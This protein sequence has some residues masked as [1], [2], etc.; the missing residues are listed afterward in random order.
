MA[1]GLHMRK[2]S[3][4][5]T[6]EWRVPRGSP[7]RKA[8]SSMNPS[9]LQAIAPFPRLLPVVVALLIPAV[10]QA[11]NYTWV[12]SEGADWIDAGNWSP[13]SPAAT[14]GSG[15]GNTFTISS[16]TANATTNTFGASLTVSG[17]GIL[18]APNECPT[19]TALSLNG[20]T[21]KMS[22][23]GN[24]A[25]SIT[26]TANSTIESADADYSNSFEYGPFAGITGTSTRTLAKTGPGILNL[27]AVDRSASY[28]GN[29]NVAG[30]VVLVGEDDVATY[31]GSGAMVALTTAGSTLRVMDYNYAQ[32]PW[33]E[34]E[35]TL[36]GIGTLSFNE[37]VG[38]RLTRNSA[39]TAGGL[40]PGNGTGA[41]GTLTANFDGVKNFTFRANVTNDLVPWKIDVLSSTS[42]DNIVSNGYLQGLDNAALIIDAKEAVA[43]PITIYSG[44]IQDLGEMAFGSVTWLNGA[45]G[46]VSYNEDGT[47][48]LSNIT[49][50]PEP[51]TV[52]LLGV[53]GAALLIRRRL[54]RRS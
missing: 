8:A 49:V 31:L 35:K 22:Y 26:V 29:W 12:G 6:P 5:R 25:G 20:G 44:Y 45:D 42:F 11:T 33:V 53:V 30:G 48:T 3:S 51:A 34:M 46:T 39:N 21:L 28:F 2:V 54:G 32:R 1:R 40:S 47:I 4:G 24:F 19:V 18:H 10:A 16:G 41:V 15:S 36:E 17:T 9:R 43:G 50:V 38:I 52:S 27:T 14:F 37:N 23:S 7:P 13:A